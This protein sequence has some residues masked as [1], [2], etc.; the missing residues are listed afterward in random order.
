M[1]SGALAQW[2]R[3][4]AIEL[5]HE[6]ETMPYSE[7]LIKAKAGEML[8]RTRKID[9]GQLEA[10]I[11]IELNSSSGIRVSITVNSGKMLELEAGYVFEKKES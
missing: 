3:Q 6:Y 5:G 2:K 7:L 9:S 1:K 11:S 10:E 4:F 8:Y